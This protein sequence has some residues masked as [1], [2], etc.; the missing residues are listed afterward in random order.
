MGERQGSCPPTRSLEIRLRR[1]DHGCTGVRLA[2][3]DLIQYD[4]Y[5]A[6]QSAGMGWWYDS[7]D[8][9]VVVLVADQANAELL[10]DYDPNIVDPRP[11]VMVQLQVTVPPDTPLDPVVHVAS[12]ANGWVHQP[13]PW[14]SQPNTATGALSVPRG[15]WFYYKYTRGS[16]GT[17]EK[18]PGCVEASNRYGF[19]AAH[20]ERRDEVFAWADL[21][22]N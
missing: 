21:C 4:S 17:V 7:R 3:N 18:W 19:G 13:L 6:L 5:E 14:D 1:V 2:G 10:F 22:G 16:W 11:P 9:A 8:L 20:P 12:S 15:E